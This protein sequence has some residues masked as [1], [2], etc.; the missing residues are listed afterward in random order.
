MEQPVTR[1]AG[2]NVRAHVCRQVHDLEG[3]L[4]ELAYATPSGERSMRP[5]GSTSPGRIGA[6]R[7]VVPVNGCDA[8]RSQPRSVPA[9]QGGVTTRSSEGPVD[10]AVLIGT[11][12]IHERPTAC[13]KPRAVEAR[14]TAKEARKPG[15]GADLRR[16]IHREP[17]RVTALGVQ[18]LL[19]ASGASVVS[20][21]PGFLSGFFGLR[22]PVV[23]GAALAARELTGLAVSWA[24]GARDSGSAVGPVGN[25]SV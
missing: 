23:G 24:A 14:E 18:T 13:P 5:S 6:C 12:S 11:R 20:C 25:R 22:P 7:K 2:W 21:F 4:L 10:T 8:S 9:D 3:A 16:E 19:L 15:K 1:P 17:P